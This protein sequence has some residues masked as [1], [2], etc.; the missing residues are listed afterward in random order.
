MQNSAKNADFFSS[1]KLTTNPLGSNKLLSDNSDVMS[2]LFFGSVVIGERR[3]RLT[4]SERF[5]LPNWN[6]A[7]FKATCANARDS[8]NEHMR[9]K[10]SF[11]RE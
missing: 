11:M 7:P 6:A 4:T 5:E 2:G 1:S 8:E 9:K 10:K 3:H